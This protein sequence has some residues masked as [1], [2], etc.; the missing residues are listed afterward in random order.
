M[1]IP[2]REVRK[3]NPHPTRHLINSAT[4]L[5]EFMQQLDIYCED[6]EARIQFLLSGQDIIKRIEN[7]TIELLHYKA[8]RTFENLARGN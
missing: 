4:E 1:I 2:F 3:R 6:E 8:M 7:M 5:L